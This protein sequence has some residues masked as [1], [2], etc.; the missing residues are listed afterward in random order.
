MSILVN[1]YYL[2]K[3]NSLCHLRQQRSSDRFQR[4]QKNM[5]KCFSF[6]ATRDQCFRYSFSRT[7]LKSTSIKLHEGATV[8]HIWIPKTQ[9][10]NKP[11]LLLIH[12]FGANAMWQYNDFISPLV[13]KFNVYI[14]DL[15]FFGDSYTSRPERTEQFQAECLMAALESVGVVDR[16]QVSRTILFNVLFSFKK[17]QINL[18]L[19]T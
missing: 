5:A 13:T 7:G 11:N 9:K 16:M 18:L 14:P 19:I 6:T 12:G 1:N 10:P 2:T 4:H 8:I 17:V 15:L 3:S